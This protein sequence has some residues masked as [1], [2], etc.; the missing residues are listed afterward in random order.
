MSHLPFTIL[1]YLLNSVAVTIDKFLLTKHFPD[2][3]VYV[4]YFS[5]FSLVALFLLP[6]TTPPSIQTFAMASISTLLWTTGAYFMFKAVQKGQVSRVIPIIG[7]LTPLLLLIHAAFFGNVTQTQFLAAGILI[8]GLLFLTLS[9]LKGRPSKQELILEFF[10]A[11]LFAVSYLILHEAY[12]MD[13]FLT[14]LVYSRFILLPVGALIL[15]IP[16]LRRIVLAQNGPKINFLSKTGALFLIGQMAGGTSEILL[17]FSIALATPALVNSLQGVQYGF[18]FLFS[19]ILAKI[20][21]DVYHEKYTR[22]V[23]SQ[24]ILG[25]G[26]IGTGLYLLA[27]V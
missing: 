9:D 1:A 10:A 3:L 6:F 27:F 18:L 23:L 13:Y 16:K 20:F 7:T 14:V 21:P 24:K 5:V 8:F 2:P 11:T 25:I 12:K 26:M 15:I 19:I 22:L 17:T 4:F